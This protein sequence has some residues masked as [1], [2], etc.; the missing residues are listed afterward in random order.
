M[1][2]GRWSWRHYIGYG[3]LIAFAIFLA[4]EGGLRIASRLSQ[5]KILTSGD[6]VDDCNAL[7]ILCF[8]D[9]MTYGLGV[10]P[11]ESYPMLLDNALEKAFPGIQFKVYNLGVPGYNSSEVLNRAKEFLF[12]ER[13]ARPDFAL[14]LLGVNNRWNF[15]N[16][17]FWDRE[18]A[19]RSEHWITYLS[20]KLKLHKA[21]NLARLSGREMIDEIRTVDYRGYRKILEEKGWDSFFDTFD[22]PLL[23]R[24]MAHDLAD[25]ATLLRGEEIEPLL[26]TYFDDRFDLL[27]PLLTQIADEARMP[28]VDLEKEESYY[29]DRGMFDSDRF[30]LNSKGYKD[31][32]GRV[33]ER[34]KRLYGMQKIK[35][36]FAEKKRSLL[37]RGRE[38]G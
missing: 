24:W 8:G 32:V 11:A 23:K 7:V 34:F 2:I 27:N 3:A 20:S 30:H 16:A 28:V 38:G 19:A 13:D 21:V 29:N 14:L 12:Y 6:D 33:A 4:I 37:C 10:G 26:L 5:P 9:S 22:H 31:V 35:A 25:I 18:G 1:G 36:E 17:S 15:F